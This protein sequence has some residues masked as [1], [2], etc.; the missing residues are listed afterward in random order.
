MYKSTSKGE[1]TTLKRSHLINSLDGI[2][3]LSTAMRLTNHSLR[4]DFLPC[5]WCWCFFVL[6][7]LV[8]TSSIPIDFVL[9]ASFP[10][11]RFPYYL[12]LIEAS[13]LSLTPQWAHRT[14]SIIAHWLKQ[15]STRIIE[16]TAQHTSASINK[17][18]T[19]D[20]TPKLHYTFE[21]V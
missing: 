11:S 17:S 13:L 12:I 6:I 5:C 19:S 8:I 7:F 4:L 10:C 3:N 16:Y 9:F 14:Q 2:F 18:H 20:R 15:T 1:K 21:S